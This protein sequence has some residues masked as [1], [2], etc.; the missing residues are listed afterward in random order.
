MHLYYQQI[1]K[2]D[3]SQEMDFLWTTLNKYF[4]NKELKKSMK[5]KLSY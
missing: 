1:A 3:F 5:L 2:Y 4:Q